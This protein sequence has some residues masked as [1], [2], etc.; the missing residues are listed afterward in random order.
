MKKAEHFWKGL[1]H[2]RNQISPVPPQTYGER[3]LNFITGITKSEEETVRE[4][5]TLDR[6]PGSVS[7]TVQSPTAASQQQ[8]Q[9]QQQQE[10]VDKTM[11][12]AE[13]AAVKSS[14]TLAEDPEP[15]ERVL[16]TVRTPVSAP[17][18]PGTGGPSTLP[19]VEE[20]GENGNGNWN[21]N[22]N[23]NGEK[24]GRSSDNNN[25]NNNDGSQPPEGRLPLRVNNAPPPGPPPDR[26]PPSPPLSSSS[27]SR[28]DGAVPNV[29]GGGGGGGSGSS[30]RAKG[31]AN[32]AA[33]MDKSTAPR[34]PS[35]GPQKTRQS[36]VTTG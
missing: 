30:S 25:N 13:K 34:L 10:A 32:N 36:W 12:K 31:K 3:F 7:E 15:R 23:W 20:I 22:W 6:A 2:N 35:L 28:A 18:A 9:Q 24:R 17:E 21:W 19:V 8:P 26:L 29:G 1:S 16:S 33:D 5:Q 4:S 27:S 11:E 14:K